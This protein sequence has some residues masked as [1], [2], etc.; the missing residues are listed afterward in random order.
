MSHSTGWNLFA[1]ELQTILQ[2]HGADLGKLDNRAAI[3]PEKVRRL[4]HSLS[5]PKRFPTLSPAD[6]DDVIQAF[7]LSRDDT[8]RLRAAVLATAVQRILMD[9]VVADEATRA[10][11]YI[12]GVVLSSLRSEA[13]SLSGVRGSASKEYLMS[14]D[15]TEN[16][17]LDAALEALLD[18][19]DR[20]T[21]ALHLSH[22]AA[23]QDERI[24]R[25]R[26]AVAAFELAVETLSNLDREIQLS[27]SWRHWRA[28]AERGAST[29]Q[30]D[31][32][33]LGAE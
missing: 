30:S 5:I 2:E 25:L 28:E 27:P 8:L 12:Y 19:I 33:D 7:Q 4:Q 29:A 21:L 3:H 14:D 31:L 26:E 15:N 22:D 17:E 11:E 1:R 18:A 6:L 20:G 23:S 13:E 10:A 24:E 32:A 16:A 9:R